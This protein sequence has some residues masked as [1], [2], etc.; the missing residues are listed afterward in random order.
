MKRW[1]FISFHCPK[2]QDVIEF[3]MPTLACVILTKS[4]ISS[5]FFP[6]ITTTFIW[7]MELFR[8]V[9]ENSEPWHK[10]T[11]FRLLWLIREPSRARSFCTSRCIDLVA[12]YP[13]WHSPENASVRLIISLEILLLWA[14]LLSE[15]W[16]VCS[17]SVH[18]W[19]AQCPR[20]RRCLKSD[21]QYRGCF[22]DFIDDFKFDLQ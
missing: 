5:S 4:I 12:A 3:P 16:H 6:R 7:K 14:Q 17:T 22:L 8:W 19:S 13:G 15:P 11:D 21:L 18:L 20:S 2:N 10:D 1:T 9:F